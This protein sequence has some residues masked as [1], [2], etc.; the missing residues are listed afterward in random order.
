M[1]PP[2]FSFDLGDGFDKRPPGG[3]KILSRSSLFSLL[4][5]GAIA[6]VGT[7]IYQLW[8]QG[9]WE[10]PK[11]VKGKGPFVIEE[12]KKDPGR[13]QL[14]STKE[15]IERNPFDPERGASKSRETEASSVAMQRIRGMVLLGTVILG[16]SRYAILQ[17]SQASRPSTPRAQ[18]AQ[19]GQLRLKLGDTVEGFKLTDIHE[20]GVV[21]TQGAS[22]VEVPLDF[23][24]KVDD[25]RVK[26]KAPVQT[27]PGVT[28]NLPRRE[29][30]PAAPVTP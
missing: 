2:F 4:L 1:S 16:K 28:P 3:I 27:R 21:F 5:L 18:P 29:R 8:Q 10:L 30:L 26:A 13:P 20:K 9:P 12:A 19:P 7:K 25:A 11:L 6:L 14:T 23:L 17:E 22:R 24:R 15:I